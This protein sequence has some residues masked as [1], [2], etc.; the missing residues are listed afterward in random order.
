MIF[1]AKGIDTIILAS[2]I[3]FLRI[4]P[5][6]Q[7]LVLSYIRKNVFIEARNACIL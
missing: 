5:D 2:I 1:Q 3:I 7:T 6:I 4:I